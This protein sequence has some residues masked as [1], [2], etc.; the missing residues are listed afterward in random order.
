[1]KSPPSV[2][3]I[4]IGRRGE[5]CLLFMKCHNKKTDGSE[6]L[7]REKSD[8]GSFPYRYGRKNPVTS[9]EKM[10]SFGHLTAIDVTYSKKLLRSCFM[11]KPVHSDSAFPLPLQLFY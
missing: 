1:M 11:P 6:L 5:F 8:R 4:G 9:Y 3:I 2:V 7:S 10:V